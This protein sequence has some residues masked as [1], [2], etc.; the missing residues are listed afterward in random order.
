MPV[1]SA[2]PNDDIDNPTYKPALMSQDGP[3]YAR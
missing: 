1:L 2:H 3:Q